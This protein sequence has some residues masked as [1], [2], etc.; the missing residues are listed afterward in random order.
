MLQKLREKSSGLLGTIVLAILIVPLGLFGI[1]QYLVQNTNDTVARVEAPPSWWPSA[2]TWWPASML[3]QQEEVSRDDFRTR[4]D[5]AR[6]Q[7]RAQQGEA[8]DPREFESLENKREVLEALI[9]QRVQALASRSAGIAVSDA[10]VR[11]T[12]RDIPAFQ[13]DGEFNAERYQLAL[14]SQVPTQSP[15]AFEQTVREGLQQSLVPVSLSGSNFVTASEMQRLIRLIGERRDAQMLFLPPQEQDETEVGEQTI[16]SWYESHAADFRAPETVTLEYVEIQASELPAPAP[17]DEEVLR[18]RYKNEMAKFVTPEERL[19]SHILIELAPDADEAA[20]KAA[21]DKA[22]QVA[23]QAKAADADFAALASGN[24]DDIGSKDSGGDLGWVSKGMM[25]GPFEEALFAMTAPGVSDPVKTEFGWHV[26]Q[27]REIKSGEVEPFEQVRDALAREQAEADRERAINDLM[28]GVVDQVY[29][30]PNNLDGVAAE[31]QLQVQKLGPVSRDSGDGIMANPAVKRAAFD[32][33]RIQDG[34]ISDPIEMEPGHHVLIRVAAHQPERARPLDEVRDEVIAAVRADQVM[35]ATKADA[36][37][38]LERLKKGETLQ[39][40]AESKS[41][42]E[43]QAMPGIMRGMPL[44][45]AAVNEAMFAVQ[46]PK[47]GSPTPGMAMLSSGGA[48]LFTVDKVTPGDGETI[49][50]GEREMLREQLRQVAGVDDLKAYTA[51]LRQQMQV[52]VF[53]EN[54]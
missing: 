13:I 27:L 6:Q 52:S 20:Q 48:V 46:A 37:A 53:E 30:N 43:P 15:K 29:K 51:R 9:D 22:A 1:D 40:I 10:L 33:A 28:T 21:Q 50:E 4:F 47:E 5:L 2:P 23:A 42:P 49:G 3:W 11:K 54:L 25:V 19:A 41:L 26:I 24:S 18:T 45:D 12:I 32:E 8:F 16:K 39:A 14:A 35:Q 38:L 31:A 7:A 44:P 36:E 17:A 34:T